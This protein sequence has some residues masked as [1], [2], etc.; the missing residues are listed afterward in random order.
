MSQTFLLGLQCIF[1]N[2]YK[3]THTHKHKH[4]HK[5]T[6]THVYKHAQ[7][8]C[9]A[10]LSL[11]LSLILSLS[12]SLCLSLTL[13]IYMIGNFIFKPVRTNLCANKYSYCFF[14][15]KRFQLSNIYN[16]IQYLFVHTDVIS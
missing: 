8:Y 16:S 14:I 9:C 7:I 13:L 3:H 6:N 12:L 4:R 2:V 1:V 11:S 5:D 15:V 10:S